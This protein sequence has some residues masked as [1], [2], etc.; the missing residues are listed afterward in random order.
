MII[1]Q[2]FWWSIRTFPQIN[3]RASDRRITMCY[4]RLR[5]SWP[6]LSNFLAEEMSLQLH[7]QEF[8]NISCLTH[9]WLCHLTYISA[10]Q[11]VYS[12]SGP[13]WSRHNFAPAIRGH[14]LH[15]KQVGHPIMSRSFLFYWLQ[16]MSECILSGPDNFIEGSMHVFALQAP[17]ILL[18]IPDSS[19]ALPIYQGACMMFTTM[20]LGWMR[21]D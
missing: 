16:S 1:L 20:L 3:L 17:E 21:P 9:N 7:K 19:K 12:L 10:L 4:V 11:S 15:S 6:E 13:C 2:L 5:Q 18:N 14:G 8:I